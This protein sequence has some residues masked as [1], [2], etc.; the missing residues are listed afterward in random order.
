MTRMIRLVS[1]GADDILAFIPFRSAWV[2]LLV[3]RVEYRVARVMGGDV[4]WV[5]VGM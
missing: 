1:G 2:V 3:E 5:H 4:S